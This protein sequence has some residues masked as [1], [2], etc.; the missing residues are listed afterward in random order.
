[1]PAEAL[2]QIAEPIGAML[3]RSSFALGV[4]SSFAGRAWRIRDR[5][6]DAARALELSGYSAALAQLLASRHLLAGQLQP[7]LDIPDHRVLELLAVLPE[8]RHP[9]EETECAQRVE[10][11]GRSGE[12]GLGILDDAAELFK[13]LFLGFQNRRDARIHRQAAKIARPRD[14]DLLERSA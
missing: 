7:L 1:M 4:N 9:V 2:A 13:R 5:D 14:A 6:E 11:L 10:G 3:G 8:E 12:V